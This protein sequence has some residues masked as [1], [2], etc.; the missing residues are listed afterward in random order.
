ML[1]FFKSL[2]TQQFKY[3]PH[4]W[5]NPSLFVDFDHLDFILEIASLFHIY[6]V[7]TTVLDLFKP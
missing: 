6:I 2:T 3:H 1:C 4:I 5:R 7:V